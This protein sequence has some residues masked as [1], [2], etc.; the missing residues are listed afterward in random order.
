MKSTFAY[1]KN[2]KANEY[3][4]KYH[5]AYK[6]TALIATTKYTAYQVNFYG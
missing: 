2:I 3:N 1:R 5:K 4:E 6:K